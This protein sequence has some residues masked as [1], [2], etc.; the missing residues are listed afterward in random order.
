MVG[1]ASTW[2]LHDSSAIDH[3]LAVCAA[4]RHRIAFEDTQR[5]VAPGCGFGLGIPG[6]FRQPHVCMRSS[7]IVD[8]GPPKPSPRTPF[9]GTFELDASRCAGQRQYQTMAP[10]NAKPG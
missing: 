6:S 4:T 7:S 5:R 8:V 10:E 2:R 3:A 1:T 9:Q